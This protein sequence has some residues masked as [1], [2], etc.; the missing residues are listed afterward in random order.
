MQ[1]EK[2]VNAIISVEDYIAMSD[3]CEKNERSRAW[4]IRK[5]IDEK[6]EREGYRNALAE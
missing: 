5:A 1:T 2:A 6:L 4:F 3:Y